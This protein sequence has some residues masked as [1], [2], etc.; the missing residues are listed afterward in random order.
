[1]YLK[2]LPVDDLLRLTI[3]SHDVPLDIVPS[4]IAV[5]AV[6]TVLGL[7]NGDVSIVTL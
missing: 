5:G 2:D 7:E 1:M 3:G 4:A 6:I